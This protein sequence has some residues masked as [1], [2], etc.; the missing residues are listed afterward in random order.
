M[1]MCCG[2]STTF[3]VHPQ[4]V[5]ALQGLEPKVV[6][7]EVAVVDDLAV[8]PEGVLQASIAVSNQHR[9]PLP[10]CVAQRIPVTP[11]TPVSNHSGFLPGALALVLE[12]HL[13][14]QM[15][16]YTSSATRGDL[17]PRLLVDV[18]KHVLHTAASVRKGG[19][20]ISQQAAS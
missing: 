16:W 3:A 5:G 20:S 4:E 18:L 11:I 1:S 15:M 7:L 14:L 13:T 10:E 2:R 6:V 19:L 12:P 8:Q 17:E 9:Q